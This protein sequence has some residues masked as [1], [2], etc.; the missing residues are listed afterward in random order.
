MRGRK[1]NEKGMK[2]GK[3]HRKRKECGSQEKVGKKRD[4]VER[5]PDRA[6]PIATS[7]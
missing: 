5:C 1:E 2:R 6:E 3:E 7:L 4:E